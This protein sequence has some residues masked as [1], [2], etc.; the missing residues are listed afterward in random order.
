MGDK[1]TPTVNLVGDRFDTEAAEILNTL[2]TQLPGHEA[3]NLADAIAHAIRKATSWH[4]E[5]VELVKPLAD[6]ADYLQKFFELDD[7]LNAV[8]AETHLV[9]PGLS[10]ADCQRARAVLAKVE[11]SDA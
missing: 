4:K 9:M 7:P 5:L 2:P 6:H 11:A 8:D 1:S 3:A 10:L